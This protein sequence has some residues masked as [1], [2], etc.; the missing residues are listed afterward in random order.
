MTVVLVAL[1]LFIVAIGFCGGIIAMRLLDRTPSVSLSERPFTWLIVLGTGGHYFE[2][3][4]L[5]S[6][7]RRALEGEKSRSIRDRRVF[8]AAQEDVAKISIA[9]DDRF[10]DTLVP[11][12]RARQVHQSYLSSIVST[13]YAVGLALRIVY[14]E[15]PDLVLCNGP[16]TCVPLCIAAFLLNMLLGR[17][18]KIVYVESIARVT[19]LSLSGK[20]LY[21]ICDMFVL[22]WPHLLKKYPR[23]VYLGRLL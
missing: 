12:T 1:L 11:I 2:M 23:A 5:L 22:T 8:V 6:Q 20:I 19:S 7:M 16:G 9:R 21:P 18:T 15:R 3:R 17:H 14:V 4:R 13:L 10:D